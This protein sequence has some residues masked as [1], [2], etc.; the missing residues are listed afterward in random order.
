MRQVMIL[1]GSDWADASADA[2]AVPDDMDLEEQKRLYRKWLTEDRCALK[3]EYQTFYTWLL[4]HG[5]E[6]STIE[7]FWE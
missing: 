5:C 2:V 6:E 7:E 1:G 4:N 3:Q